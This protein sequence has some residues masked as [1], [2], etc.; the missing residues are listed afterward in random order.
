M[1]RQLRRLDR[2]DLQA[3]RRPRAHRGRLVL[4]VA[5][6]AAAA[7][8]AGAWQV[9]AF[10]KSVVAQR[11][12]TVVVPGAPTTTHL[13]HLRRLLPSAAAPSTSAPYRFLQKQQGRPLTWEPCRAI[14]YVVHRQDEP[15]AFD[16]MLRSSIAEV[17]R[18]TGLKFVNDG[19]TAEAPLFNMRDRL[20]YQPSLYGDRWAPVL[21]AWSNSVQ[22]PGL[23]NAEGFAGPAGFGGSGYTARY[24]SGAVVYDVD[25]LQLLMTEPQG[26]A[27]VRMVLLHELG[28]LVGLGHSPAKSQVMF[29][30]VTFPPHPHYQAG[31]LAGLAVLGAGRCYSDF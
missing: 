19:A 9:G 23:A 24:V 20:I 21:I 5:L 29:R 11:P 28:H 12:T 1:D 6:I 18:A 7:T 3:T 10:R 4:A 8:L 25:K 15:K 30:G 31:D 27:A 13:S 26:A 17:S 16:R 2:D 22:S 14:H